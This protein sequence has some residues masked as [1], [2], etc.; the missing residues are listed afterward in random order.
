MNGI[1][2]ARGLG[3]LQIGIATG[4]LLSSSIS[5]ASFTDA[6]KI[7]ILSYWKDPSRFSVTPSVSE[8]GPWVVRLTPDGS[9]WLYTVNK[10]ITKTGATKAS[11]TK[12]SAVDFK[13]KPVRTKVISSDS[14]AETLVEITPQITSSQLEQ[15]PLDSK[16]A[17]TKPV[18]FESWIDAK[19][20][21]YRYLAAVEAQKQNDK[22]FDRTSPEI[23][24]VDEPT[25]IPKGLL[26]NYG[27]PPKLAC[28]VRPN[29]YMVR[30]D[31]DLITY[32]DNPEMRPRYISFRFAT[33]V[34]SAGS[35]IKN[36]P[37]GEFDSLI[38]S[39]SY[40]ESE[41][42]VFK[43]VSNLEGGFD[44]VN[45]YDTGFVSIGFIQFAALKAGAGSLGQTLLTYKIDDP[46]GYEQDFRRFG[47][48]V[49][50]DGQLVVLD[51]AT[52]DEKV[53]PDANQQI[54]ADKRLVAVF[55][56]AGRRRPYRIAQL[57]VAHQMYYPTEERITVNTP[58]GPLVGRLGDIIKSEAGLATCVDMKVNTGQITPIK[59]ALELLAKTQ[60]VT[61]FADFAEYEHAI[62]NCVWY[63]VNY[64]FVPDLSQP[65]PCEVVPAAL[66]SRYS[67]RFGRRPRG[68]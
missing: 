48:D 28:A 43:A 51:L 67:S 68:W 4:I 1:K 56:R 12:T 9:R 36:L 6:E 17:D 11:N 13:K 63:R 42:R 22:F 21:Y 30:F 34:M 8:K 23:P 26:A 37:Q 14:T 46:V 41:A 35:P 27:Q 44:S 49:T 62:I 50:F 25:E 32:E 33:G 55:Q 16:V 10:K 61:S 39:A 64:T 5:H 54:I 40:S 57:K 2:R 24:A 15:K 52:G 29:A 65:K 38:S 53:G 45:T 18:D 19:V 47:V 31:D 3:V 58:E 59:E 20:A 66:M 60:K 7:S